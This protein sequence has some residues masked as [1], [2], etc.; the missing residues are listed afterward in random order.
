MKSIEKKNKVI[1][2]FITGKYRG[3]TKTAVWI[4]DNGKSFVVNESEWSKNVEVPLFTPDSSWD[5]LMPVVE[6]IEEM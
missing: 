3:K 6:K 4:D 2:E 1:A 5:W